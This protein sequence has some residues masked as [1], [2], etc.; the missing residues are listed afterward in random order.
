MF[1]SNPV[2]IIFKKKQDQTLFQKTDPIQTYLKKN[3]DLQPIKKTPGSAALMHLTQGKGDKENGGV[4]IIWQYWCCKNDQLSFNWC[5]FRY[6][7]R[8]RIAVLSFNPEILGILPKIGVSYW[9]VQ[10]DLPNYG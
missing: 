8:K 4:A 2:L 1:R 10:E 5:F 6:I 9:V 3:P 7:L